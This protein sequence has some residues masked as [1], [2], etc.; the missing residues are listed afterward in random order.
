[1]VNRPLGI[2]SRIKRKGKEGRLGVVESV[3]GH[4]LW[5]V[6]FDD[7]DVCTSRQLSR[8][9]E[10]AESEERSD[11]AGDGTVGSDG[12][13]SEEEGGSNYHAS[14]EMER[15]TIAATVTEDLPHV[16]A[17]IATFVSA[18]SMHMDLRMRNLSSTSGTGCSNLT[19]TRT[20]CVLHS[21]PALYP[22]GALSLY[23]LDTSLFEQYS[24]PK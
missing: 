15:R 10:S 3:R 12:G 20:N 23:T 18:S 17:S 21:L 24:P 14:V 13:E 7:G 8:V 16:S 5:R 9:V 2:G 1:M 22:W 11:V 6:R 4:H 19:T